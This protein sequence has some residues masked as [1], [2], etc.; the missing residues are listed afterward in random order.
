MRARYPYGT[1]LPPSDAPR[2]ECARLCGDPALTTC[3]LAPEYRDAFFRA[4]SSVEGDGGPNDGGSEGGDSGPGP[5]AAPPTR[6]PDGF[7]GVALTC[8]QYVSRGGNNPGCPIEGRKPS[9]LLPLE[10]R[11]AG[12]AEAN[13]VA[14]YLA[15]SAH[16]EAASVH[17][18]VALARA[19]E[20]HGAPCELVA[21]CRG[22]AREEARHARLVGELARRAGGCV[23]PVVVGPTALPSLLALALENVVEGVVRE[24]Y[25]AAQAFA[26]AA[27][28]ED[29]AVGEAMASIAAEEAQHAEL[30]LRIHAFLWSKLDAG[31]RAEVDA[32][33]AAAIAGLRRDLAGE[34]M[35]V[36]QRTLGV[37]SRA[38]ALAMVEELEA[39]GY[40]RQDTTPLWASA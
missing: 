30:S 39:R 8:E 17:A 35:P 34:V 5:D 3:R 20:A 25:G 18:F 24:A 7:A 37:P 12:G 11:G 14:R 13:A 6:C 31:E 19:L 36:L 27:R 40:W 1:D 38:Q 4:N 15:E 33:R 16:L 29:R 23:P 2:D 10:G 9:G 32:A 28:A 21:A 26:R 22:A